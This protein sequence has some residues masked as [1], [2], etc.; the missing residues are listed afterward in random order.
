[1]AKGIIGKK[2]GMSQI[3]NDNGTVVPVTVIEAGPCVVTQKKDKGRDGYNAI[4]MGF[5]DK[6]ESRTNKPEQGHFKRTGVKPRKYMKEFRDFSGEVSEGDEITVKQFAEGELVDVTGISR[7]KGFAGTIKR[8][9]FKRGPKTHGSHSIRIPGSIGATDAARVFK[10]K[11]LPG[12]MGNE[13][14]TVQSLEIIRVDLDKNLLLI[15]GS[16]PGPRN[17]ILAIK[18][19]VKANN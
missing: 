19:A 14:V 12:R 7:G 5:I 10:G 4:Q 13:R 17:G 8:Y 1:M 16:V 18:E 2:L 9:N 3:F 6:S 11:K 15:K